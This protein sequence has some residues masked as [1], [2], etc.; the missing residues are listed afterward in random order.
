MD[1]YKLV[2]L[3]A[4]S[5]RSDFSLVSQLLLIVQHGLIDLVH[6][7]IQFWIFVLV[8][9]SASISCSCG[10]SIFVDILILYVHIA[11]VLYFGWDA[12]MV[13]SL[14]IGPVG[15]IATKVPL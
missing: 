2:N 4:N 11:W 1:E 14:G 5:E 6:V 7:W 15:Q 8:V 10:G 9:L 12:L 13:I 3:V